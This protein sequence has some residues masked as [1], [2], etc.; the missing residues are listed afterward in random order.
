M[1]VRVLEER[2]GVAWCDLEEVV[3]ERGRRQRDDEPRVE[4]AVPEAHRRVHVGGDEGEVV[5]APPVHGVGC[6]GH[7]TEATSSRKLTP[8]SAT[9]GSDGPRVHGRAGG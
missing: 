3:P 2:D 4:D 6:R 1:R 9:A 8:T 5:D 7:G